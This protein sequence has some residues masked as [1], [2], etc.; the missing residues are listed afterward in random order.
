[1][2][3]TFFNDVLTDPFHRRTF[4][5]LALNG[6]NLRRFTRP[7][8]FRVTV[9][10]QWEYSITATT[11]GL[12]GTAKLIRAPFSFLRAELNLQPTNGLMIFTPLTISPAFKSSL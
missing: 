7:E 2:T 8:T 11:R 12:R 10:T 1:M 3:I 4:K 9:R 6:K 5:L